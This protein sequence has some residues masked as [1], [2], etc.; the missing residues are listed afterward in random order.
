M[1][2]GAATFHPLRVAEV[3]R[4]CEDAREV[5][6]EVPEGLRAR[7][8]HEPGQYLTLRTWLD[9]REVRRCYSICTPPGA[10]LAVG[11]RKVPGGAFSAH[12]CRNLA[13]G[14]T[15][16]AM[17]P[18]G[19]FVAETGG[20]VR[21][22]LVAAGS[23]ITPVLAIAEATLAGHPGAEVALVYGNRRPETIMFRDRLEAL[24][25][26]YLDRFTLLH[27]LSRAGGDV[28]LL[29]GRIDAGRLE[30][31]ARAGAIAPAAA[32]AVFLCGPEAMADEA[33]AA[34]AAL[35]VAP[36]RI[37]RERF[38]TGDGST[39]VAPPRPRHAGPADGTGRVEVIIDGARKDFT[40]RGDGTVL[41]EA[42]A[43]GLALPYSCR[44]GMCCTC[45]CRIV[46]GSAEMDVN[47]SLEPW[48]IARGF[49]L[50]CQARPTS[51]RLV[52]DFDAT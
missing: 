35:G 19:R 17:P 20:P 25:D 24:K 43:A 27:V 32:D 13:P 49:V 47:Y 31:L 40:P 50:A 8:A 39:P 28:P 52:L 10:P 45:R 9:G 14:D 5:V 15:L 7:F 38:V 46:E 4:L 11:V 3:R 16:E 6:L 36:E 21:Y 34:M 41:A 37:R 2:L 48:E 26:R 33:A 44:G 1:P 29:S 23:G 30:A 18:S 42:E 12:V 51:D 22:L